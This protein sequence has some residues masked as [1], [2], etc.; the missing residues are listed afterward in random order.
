MCPVV[1]D[2]PTVAEIT[3]KLKQ[4]IDLIVNCLRAMVYIRDGEMSRE[5][6]RRIAEDQKFIPVDY[7]FLRFREVL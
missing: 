7:P 4:R 2:R 6:G 3:D 5:N 1:K